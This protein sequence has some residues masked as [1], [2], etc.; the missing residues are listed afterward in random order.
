[1]WT[2]DYDP[3]SVGES[4]FGEFLDG[5]DADT[6]P[7]YQV[8]FVQDEPVRRELYAVLDSERAVDQTAD[9][10]L[11][12]KGHGDDEILLGMRN[13]VLADAGYRVVSVTFTDGR[14]RAP[15]RL[16]PGPLANNRLQEELNAED[17]QG[18]SVFANFGVEDGTAQQR[19]ETI[20]A[21]LGDV[22]D[23]TQP[24]AIFTTHPHDAHRDHAAIFNAALVVAGD[25][26]VV[27]S[28]TPSMRD[29]DGR[30]L[31][32]THQYPMDGGLVVLRDQVHG[33]YR[34]QRWGHP[35]RE[36][37]DVEMV[38]RQ[39]EMRGQE[40]RLVSGLGGVL[41]TKSNIDSSSDPRVARVVRHARIKPTSTVFGR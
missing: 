19:F 13:K 14:N 37:R 10:V 25:R 23:K 30:P 27:A 33:K 15:D 36:M 4:G 20:V 12:A 1:L 3:W 21:L 7:H 22:V 24:V 31:E 8:Q 32:Y 38:R 2:P 26:P 29:K 17:L 5:I 41:Y 16:P 11:V 28:D 34:T 40:L 9:T 35:L 39:P 6:P 18:T